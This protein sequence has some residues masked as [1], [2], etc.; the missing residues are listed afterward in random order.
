MDKLTEKRIFVPVDV[1]GEE[2]IKAATALLSNILSVTTN[3]GEIR[4]LLSDF[5]EGVKMNWEM[6]YKEENKVVLSKEELIE[7]LREAWNGTDGGNKLIYFT[8]FLESK[9]LTLTKK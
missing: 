8:T 7:L 1:K 2:N 9:G 6:K 3:I 4:N 5:L